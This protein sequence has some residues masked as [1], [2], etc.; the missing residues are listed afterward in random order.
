M[1]PLLVAVNVCGGLE[2]II[3]VGSEGYTIQPAPSSKVTEGEHLV[4]KLQSLQHYVQTSKDDEMQTLREKRDVLNRTTEPLTGDEDMFTWYE[5]RYAKH[6]AL[7]SGGP[8]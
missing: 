8:G 7:F 4:S 3:Q 2:G 6:K 1:T 5:V